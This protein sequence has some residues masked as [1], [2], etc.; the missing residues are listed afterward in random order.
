MVKRS[1]EV[2][3]KIFIFSSVYIFYYK[4]SIYSSHSSSSIKSLAIR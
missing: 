4:L 2:A 1:L 3:A